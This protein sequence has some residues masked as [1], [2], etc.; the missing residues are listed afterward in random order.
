L[1]SSKSLA[2]TPTPSNV[3]KKTPTCGK[4]R[5]RSKKT[6]S[7]NAPRSYSRLWMSKVRLPPW[8]PLPAEFAL[9]IM[10]FFG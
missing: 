10:E 4:F 9:A 3:P 8:L 7:T 1:H 2:P 5:S 6:R